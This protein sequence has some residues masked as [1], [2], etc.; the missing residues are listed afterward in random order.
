M[1]AAAAT[2]EA[3]PGA[4]AV[5]QRKLAQN[6]EL[7]VDL[8]FA[9]QAQRLDP[10]VWRGDSHLEIPA[11]RPRHRL[12]IGEGVGQGEM[13]TILVQ[14]VR[15]APC[16]QVVALARRETDGFA[17]AAFGP[18]RRSA[19]PVE[20]AHRLLLK[21]V[22]LPGSSGRLQR[23]ERPPVGGGDLADLQ[24][25]DFDRLARQGEGGERVEQVGDFEIGPENER[26]DQSGMEPIAPRLLGEFSPQF[27]AVALRGEGFQI[28]ARR[29]VAAHDVTTEH[30]QIASQ[31][32]R[33]IKGVARMRHDGTSTSSRLPC[34]MVASNCPTELAQASNGLD[35]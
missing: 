23:D 6:L 11:Q 13:R 9:E 26:R 19:Q 12:G 16:I 25:A 2:F 33:Q 34:N 3:T 5:S 22:K 4:P 18:A 29:G 20:P 8:A 28:P 30:P 14:H 17:P 10:Q 27:R 15:V 35:N 31:R 1:K 24:F 7:A 21:R 32:R